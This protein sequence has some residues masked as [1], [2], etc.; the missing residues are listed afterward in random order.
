MQD[1]IDGVYNTLYQLPWAGSVHGCGEKEAVTHLHKY[2][3]TAWLG[4]VHENQMIN[5]LHQDFIEDHCTEIMSTYFIPSL[6]QAFLNWKSRHKGSLHQLGKSLAKGNQR[7]IGTIV[8]SYK[9]HWVAIILDFG[10]QTIWHGDSLGWKMEPHTKTVLEWW[11]FTYTNI[12][13]SHRQMPITHQ[14]DTISCGLLAWNTLAHFFLPACHPLM[15][16]ADVATE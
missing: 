4:C 9:T 8:N 15:D 1:V 12:R 5:L 11:T 2:T 3:M 13:F 7:Y 16:T 14:E 10:T 6:E